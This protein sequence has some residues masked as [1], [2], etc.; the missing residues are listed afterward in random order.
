MW[1]LLFALFPAF[2]NADCID[3]STG[4][5]ME[6]VQKIDGHTYAA[7]I[8]FLLTPKRRVI[9]KTIQTT[10]GSEGRV[11][12]HLWVSDQ[13]IFKGKP[14][15]TKIETKSGFT[16]TLPVM[17][18]TAAC[19]AEGAKIVAN[20]R[21]KALKEQKLQN[22]AWEKQHKEEELAEKKENEEDNDEKAAHEQARADGTET[23]YLHDKKRE[24]RAKR[25]ATRHEA[26]KAQQE[27]QMADDAERR[28]E[29]KEVEAKEHAWF[30]SHTKKERIAECKR[31]GHVFTEQES[32]TQTYC[33]D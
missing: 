3:M 2:S 27:A 1:I 22:A 8:W 6:I 20:N 31:I 33:G 11:Q 12:D 5:G 21:A 28:S 26:W 30:E 15:M 19:I 24:K 25:E 23:E 7:D 4:G 18:E 32:P 16:K 29:A 17:R 13:G 14:E 9:L 10:F